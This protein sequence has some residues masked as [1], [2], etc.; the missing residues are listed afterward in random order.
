[1][2]TSLNLSRIR[3]I[4]VSLGVGAVL[5]S[6]VLASPAMAA[7]HSAPL[8]TEITAQLKYNPSGTVI[9]N[10]Q[11]SYDHG[12]VIVTVPASGMSPEVTGGCP[13]NWFCLYEASGYRSYMARFQV[14]LDA[15]IDWR[16]YLPFI[17]SASN[18]RHT[19]SFL[20]NL[21]TAVCYPAGAAAPAI[22]SPVDQYYYVYLEAHNNC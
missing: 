16:A 17:G 4:A 5:A 13:D 15:N 3:A 8:S 9:N 6:V 12:H 14:P 20:S 19:G 22:G 21:R 18:G 11:V 7:S 2:R 10:H 1:V